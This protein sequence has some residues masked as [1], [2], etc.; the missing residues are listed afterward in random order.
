M[1]VTIMTY[2]EDNGNGKS[3]DNNCMNNK[4]KNDDDMDIMAWSQNEGN[5]N[6]DGNSDNKEMTIMM[7]VRTRFP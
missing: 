3:E 6:N 1:M 7:T 5:H 2:D 4:Y